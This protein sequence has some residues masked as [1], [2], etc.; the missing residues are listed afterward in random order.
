MDENRPLPETP[1]LSVLKASYRCPH[2]GTELKGLIQYYGH[3]AHYHEP[4]KRPLK[5]GK[6]VSRAPM[7]S[8]L[9]DAMA[10]AGAGLARACREL[11]VSVPYFIKWAEILV[12]IEYA[13]YRKRPLIG[14]G[15]QK[16]SPDLTKS[17]AYKYAKE[18]LAGNAPAKEAW[19]LYPHRRLNQ[20]Q[21]YGILPDTCML[22]GFNEHRAFDYRTPMLMDFID[23]NQSNWLEPNLRVL[24]YNCYF[25]NVKDMCGKSK[26]TSLGMPRK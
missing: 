24:C 7:A 14:V 16:G 18:V 15:I 11:R 10:R 8:E 21:R 2:C 22:C 9:L 1:D 12:P 17:Q 6:K 5:T 20:L 3:I 19:S 23:G 4:T 26:Y 13:E 25:L